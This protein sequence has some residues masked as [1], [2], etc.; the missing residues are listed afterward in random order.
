MQPQET[1]LKIAPAGQ[2]LIVAAGQTF[3]VLSG[4]GLQPQ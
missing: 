1:L 3:G 4:F 2:G